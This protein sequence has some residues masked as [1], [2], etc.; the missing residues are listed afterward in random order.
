MKTSIYILFWGLIMLSCERN[1]KAY[2]FENAG[3]SEIS[4]RTLNEFQKLRL[5]GKMDIEIVQDSQM[6]AE[7]VTGEHLQDGI[8]FQEL[9]DQLIIS[10]KNRCL[11]LRR[12]NQFPK[13]TLHIR[14]LNSIRAD[15]YGQLLI[16]DT[17]RT[18]SIYIEVWNGNPEIK[19]GLNNI[20]TSIFIHSNS[21]S[22]DASGRVG[23][24]YL[25]NGGAGPMHCENMK[26]D[27]VFVNSH[28]TNHTYVHALQ[29]LVADI[30]WKG[31][32]FYRGK[33]SQIEINQCNEGKLIP[34][35]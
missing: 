30:L 31:N 7:I 17:L 29:W 11:W 32:I 21:G 26:C 33:P 24:A 12:L 16:K 28:S 20:T 3:K 22:V 34:W 18:D 9:G 25:S 13:V 10:N 27:V 6:Y 19:M 23:V 8:H 2:C 4:I 35:E 5:E 14:N 1:E 15:H